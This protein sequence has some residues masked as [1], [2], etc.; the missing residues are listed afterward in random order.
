VTAILILLSLESFASAYN[1]RP[2]LIVVIVIDQFRGDYLER[3]RDRF[4]DGGFRLLFDRGANF[5]E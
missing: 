5:T 3:Y 2:K 4:G 1:A